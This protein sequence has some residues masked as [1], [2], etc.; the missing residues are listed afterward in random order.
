MRIILETDNPKRF[1]EYTGFAIKGLFKQTVGHT[2]AI[3]HDSE[4]WVVSYE[5]P[6][7]IVRLYLSHD[8]K[9]SDVDANELATALDRGVD[10]DKTFQFSRIET[11]IIERVQSIPDILGVD[12]I[13]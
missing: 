5:T 7:H 13:M 2:G 9:Y 3:S 6:K 12:L 11:H 4:E 1:I 8:M 10:I